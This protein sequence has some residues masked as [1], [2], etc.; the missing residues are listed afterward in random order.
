MFLWI[1]ISKCHIQE[2]VVLSAYCEEIQH[3]SLI[4]YPLYHQKHRVLPDSSTSVSWP[5]PRSMC[6]GESP[7]RPT[8]SLRATAWST[9][10][11]LQSMVRNGVW[12]PIT[13]PCLDIPQLAFSDW[14]LQPLAEFPYSFFNS[15]CL[16]SCF[17]LF[18]VSVGPA[19]TYME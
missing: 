18:Q 15:C 5:P 6:P 16:S 9:S 17:N 2:A 11:A 3:S 10:P 8:A 13:L 14:G 19:G 1:C 4:L 7:S 12:S